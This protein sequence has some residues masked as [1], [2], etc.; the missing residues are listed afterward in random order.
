MSWRGIRTRTGAS[1][2]QSRFG[3]PGSA[4]APC[5][6]TWGSNIPGGPAFRAFCGGRGCPLVTAER[7]PRA[8]SSFGHYLTGKDSVVEIESEWTVRGRERQTSG[9]GERNS[10]T[11]VSSQKPLAN[12]GHLSV[13]HVAGPFCR[14]RDLLLIAHGP[15]LQSLRQDYA[16]DTPESKGSRFDLR[17]GPA[18]AQNT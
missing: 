16:Q 6:L 15:D 17:S 4:S 8:S 14:N 10:C 9:G 13:V 12:L 5:E 2:L 7:R 3:A 11:Q 18:T 1:V